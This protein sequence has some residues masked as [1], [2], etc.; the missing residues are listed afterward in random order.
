MTSGRRPRRPLYH[1]R[2]DG[3]MW[4]VAWI[5]QDYDDPRI[6]T[7]FTPALGRTTQ[8]GT[9]PGTMRKQFGDPNGLLQITAH[10]PVS[11]AVTVVRAEASSGAPR[12]HRVK[13]PDA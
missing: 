9:R 10:S 2:A 13:Q 7:S 8:L 12:V 3:V 1:A 5:L 11:T 4:G 6:P